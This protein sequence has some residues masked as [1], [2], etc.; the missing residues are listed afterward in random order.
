MAEQ[1]MKLTEA[2]IVTVERMISSPNGYRVQEIAARLALQAANAEIAARADFHTRAL[3][4]RDATADDPKLLAFEAEHKAIRQ[5]HE[6]TRRALEDAIAEHLVKTY[7]QPI[8][9]AEGLLVRI[10][11]LLEVRGGDHFCRQ[12][13]ELPEALRAS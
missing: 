3:E 1:R 10:G 2:Q 6:A 13:Q 12:R 7:G 8:R 9:N 5:K 11:T 4:L